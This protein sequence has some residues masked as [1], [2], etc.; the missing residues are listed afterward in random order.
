MGMSAGGDRHSVKSEMNVTPL[1]DVV[2]VLLIIF[3]VTMPLKMKYMAAQIPRDADENESTEIASKTLQLLVKSD[4]AIEI[5]E[6]LEKNTIKR[7]QLVP[8]IRPKLERQSG[9]KVIFVDAEQ[10]TGWGDFISVVDG[11]QGI[12]KDLAISIKKP[13]EEESAAA[14]A[15]P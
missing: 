13:E 6:G 2:L 9:N 5:T 4:G 11:L 1:I 7:S 10:G 12:D 3:M 14:P 8:T 15:T